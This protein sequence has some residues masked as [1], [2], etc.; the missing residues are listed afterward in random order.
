MSEEKKIHR[1]KF[2]AISQ[3]NFPDPSVNRKYLMGLVKDV[4][5]LEGVQSV[6]VAG[7]MLAGKYLK[8]LFA[9]EI[10]ENGIKDKYEKEECR[11]KFVDDWAEELSAFLPILGEGVNYHII[12]SPAPA[13]DAADGES[14]CREI[15]VR[16]FEIRDKKEKD[17]RLYLDDSEPRVPVQWPEPTEI[18]VLV[19]QNKPWYSKL[20]SNLLQRLATPF[21]GRTFTGERPALILAGC[22]GSG[23]DIP[24]YKGIPTISVP[25]LYKINRVKTT[26]SM[27]GCVVVSMRKEGDSIKY[28]LDTFD[29]RPFVSAE[30]QSLIP[31]DMPT[32]K[33]RILLH[34]SK[35]S[36]GFDTLYNRLYGF[37]L[38]KKTPEK[39]VE[40]KEHLKKNLDALVSR[41]FVVYKP[42][43]NRYELSKK[44]E[45]KVKANLK[46]LMERARRI[47][48]V[49]YACLHVGA[50]KTLYATFEH[51]IPELSEN[52]DALFGCGDIIQGLA[53][54]FECSGELVPTLNTNDKQSIKAGQIQANVL[55]QIFDKRLAKY[56]LEGLSPEEL[57]RKC[58]MKFFYCLGNHDMWVHYN[59]QGLPLR[60]FHREIVSTVLLGVAERVPGIPISILSALVEESIEKVGETELVVLNGIGIGV[61]HPHKGGAETKSARIQQVIESH[62]SRK[63]PLDIVLELVGNFHTAAAIHFP[64]FNR[65]YVGVMLGAMLKTTLFENKINKVVDHGPVVVDLWVDPKSGKLLRDTIEFFDDIVHPIDR[66]VVEADKLTESTVVGVAKYLTRYGDIPLR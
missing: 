38:E 59:K 65:T 8:S 34:L 26:E 44:L 21:A 18:R 30:R 41:G 42:E 24:S 32:E 49:A 62:V 51:L 5:E 27:V 16:L 63:H 25:A 39:V 9:S 61:T 7:G 17:I 33:K 46:T 64:Q 6:I 19:P 3:L 43:I 31:E 28:A 56:K 11:A 2:L 15:L 60:D 14:I 57:V 37:R 55:L 45:Y 23:V 10:K 48:V 36:Q 20:V 35:N 4:V 29:F 47:R 22:T 58:L 53:H 40:E 1:W 13:Y 12:Y 52:A 66:R 54:N 50:I